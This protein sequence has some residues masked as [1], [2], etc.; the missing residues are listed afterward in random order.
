MYVEQS[1]ILSMH[2]LISNSRKK[3]FSLLIFL[4]GRHEVIIQC[5]QDSF[6]VSMMSLGEGQ[7]TQTNIRRIHHL[8][9]S[10][11]TQPRD[12]VSASV[13]VP[14][15]ENQKEG[16]TVSD[17]EK[18]IWNFYISLQPSSLPSQIQLQSGQQWIHHFH[19]RLLLIEFFA[20]VKFCAKTSFS[21]I[22]ILLGS[23]NIVSLIIIFRNSNLFVLAARN[24][25]LMLHHSS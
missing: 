8:T 19:Y 25:G 12:S 24:S 21:V 3:R 22:L 9:Q 2:N 10:S 17:F 14:A 23:H 5:T 1:N 20:L 6:C 11:L 18:R 15:K 13:I 16:E 7:V 4:L